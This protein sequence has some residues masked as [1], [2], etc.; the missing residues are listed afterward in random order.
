MSSNASAYGLGAEVRQKQD[1]GEWKPIA[2]S[3]MSLTS[4]E[5]RYAQI[6][7]EAL[8]ITRAYDQLRNYVMGMSFHVETDNK[9]L[10]SLLC[11]NR[12]LEELLLRVQRFRLR[13]MQYQFTISHVPGRNLHTADILSRSPVCENR[14]NLPSQDLATA[15]N[16]YVDQ[17]LDSLLVQ[18]KILANNKMQMKCATS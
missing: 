15:S 12:R 16:E 3:S 2:Y 1:N 8:S 18:T 13:L 11:T 17:I 5:T 14:A 7:K 4:A 9:T 6:E 10:V